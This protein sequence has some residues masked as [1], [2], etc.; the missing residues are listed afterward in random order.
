MKDAQQ[1][2]HVSL[3]ALI[4]RLRAGRYVISDFQREF[5]HD[6]SRCSGN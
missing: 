3:A 2:D 4:G 6:S 5:Q 1:P